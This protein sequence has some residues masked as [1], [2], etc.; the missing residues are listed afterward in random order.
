MSP[1]V[2]HEELDTIADRYDRNFRIARAVLIWSQG[3][4]LTVATYW[5]LT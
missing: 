5:W 2:P 1:H 4:I 3:L